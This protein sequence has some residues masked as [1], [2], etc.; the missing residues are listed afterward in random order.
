MEGL[1]LREEKE[2]RNIKRER[3]TQEGLNQRDV[4]GDDAHRKWLAFGLLY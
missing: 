4:D 2:D 3:E 1:S